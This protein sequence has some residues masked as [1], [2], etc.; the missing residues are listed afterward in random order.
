MPRPFDEA[1]HAR[2]RDGFL[3]AAQHLLQTVGFDAMSVQDV[4]A[5]TGASKGAFYHYFDSKS[6]LLDAVLDRMFEEMLASAAPAIRDSEL[7]ALE[8]LNRFFAGQ[9]AWKTARRPLVLAAARAWYGDANAVARVRMRRRS[10]E[11]F[12]RLL[13][14][15]VRLGVAEGVFDV[16]DPR[17]A[18]RMVYALLQD[19]HDGLIDWFTTDRRATPEQ[20]AEVID[21]VAGYQTG[22]ERVLAAPRG[23]IHLV[24]ADTM[25]DW[26]T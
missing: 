24:D 9:G 16:D 12:A 22:M 5:R 14:D 3:D 20:V 19:F 23:A 26:L 2:R 8:R 11:E 17:V 6:D 10:A 25:R 4:L 21:A 15:V 7:S 13:T 18:A 1:A